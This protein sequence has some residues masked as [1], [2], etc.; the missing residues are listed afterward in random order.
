MKTKILH[1]VLVAVCIA[2]LSGCSL[3]EGVDN[4]LHPEKSY[5]VVS[6]EGCEYIFVSRRPWQ[7]NMSLAHKGN[8]KNP[9][10][11]YR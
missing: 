3:S 1:C 6:I 11:I 4:D 5:R 2:L 10:H 9:I 8:C 7:G